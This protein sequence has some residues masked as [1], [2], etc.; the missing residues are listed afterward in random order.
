M[1]RRADTGVIPLSIRHHDALDE[2]AD[3]LATIHQ[4]GS[5]PP[6]ESL[7]GRYQRAVQAAV[8]LHF[9]Q[10]PEMGTVFGPLID[11]WIATRRRLGDKEWLREAR[12]GLEKGVRRPHGWEMRNE[13]R[14]PWREILV[15]RAIQKAIRAQYTAGARR[16]RWAG[17]LTQL[18]EQGLMPAQSLENFTKWV[19]RHLGDLLDELPPRHSRR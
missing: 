5:A 10:H 2:F 3:V 1:R 16:V 14:G 9:D 18:T 13:A 11:E 8:R 7:D 17:I 12:Q 15:T 19:A 4:L 6:P